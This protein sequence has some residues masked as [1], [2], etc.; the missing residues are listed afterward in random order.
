TDSIPIFV[1]LSR[2]VPGTVLE[3]LGRAC[4]DLGLRSLPSLYEAA[5]RSSR[6][7]L[8]FDG[9]DEMPREPVAQ[10]RLVELLQHASW[11]SALVTSRPQG[12]K[13]GKFGVTSRRFEYGRVLPLS[14]DEIHDILQ[15][16]LIDP[17]TVSAIWEKYRAHV[18]PDLS[19]PILLLMCIR[20]ARETSKWDKLSL[21]SLYERYVGVLHAFFNARTVRGRDA[22]VPVG[23]VLDCLAEAAVLIRERSWGRS[24]LSVD[25][26]QTALLSKKNIAEVDSLFNTGMILSVAG[27]ARFV[28]LTF[29]EYGLARAMIR[30]VEAGDPAAGFVIAGISDATYRIAH[31]GLNPKTEATLIGWFRD[32]SRQVRKRAV[33]IL[34]HGVSDQGAE[35]LWAEFV[36]GSETFKLQLLRMLVVR[37]DQR[38]I[39]WLLKHGARYERSLFEGIASLGRVELLPILFD[40]IPTHGF[41]AFHCALAGVLRCSASEFLPR[42]QEA[43]AASS[44][45]TRAS[46][47][48]ILS[49]HAESPLSARVLDTFIL[50][51]QKPDSLM[52]HL[53]LAV[54]VGIP[55]S[56]EAVLHLIAV[57]KREGRYEG[58][59]AKTA[60]N[61]ARQIE[62]ELAPGS[63]DW[64]A[65]ANELRRIGSPTPATE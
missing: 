32:K 31:S 3:A 11:T 26:L 13:T 54:A 17:V 47:S 44:S 8:V 45:R 5:L 43:Y 23:D 64:T 52:R 7:V 33:G 65:L 10:A 20:L 22:Q 16:Y 60:S 9:L 30:A 46:V 1:S 56:T 40:A 2:G 28:H 25:G 34:K 4:T 14:N 55:V 38:A 24:P 19:S 49:Q 36:D 41:S 51:E 53:G 48:R 59:A 63:G 29:E 12:F 61:I 57:L 35:K 27:E 6:V 15:T 21:L 18:L 62:W 37:S 58:R 39:D 50:N 42:L